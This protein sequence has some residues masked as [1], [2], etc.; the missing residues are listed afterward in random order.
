[1]AASAPLLGVA[2]AFSVFFDP[3]FFRLGAAAAAAVVVATPVASTGIP[4]DDDDNEGGGRPISCWLDAV[5]GTF[6]VGAE[7]PEG[8]EC[9][10]VLVPLVELGSD[11][12]LVVGNDTDGA[13]TDAATAG[14]KAPTEASSCL[15]LL[16][17]PGIPS[18]SALLPPLAAAAEAAWPRVR[19]SGDDG[20]CID[21]RL[22][23]VGQWS[24]RDDVGP[25][26][27][28]V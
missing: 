5:A 23:L 9:L 17:L 28:C 22:L 10:A 20:G 1:M 3:E 25:N 11:A 2:G 12:L 13:S 15:L 7:S 26:E 14:S 16:P 8:G 18:S 6:C 19:F 24:V 21:S 4:E 27:P